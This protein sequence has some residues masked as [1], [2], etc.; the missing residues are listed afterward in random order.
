VFAS[1]SD[2]PEEIRDEI[3]VV[4]LFHVLEHISEPKNFLQ[5][6]LSRLPAVE[7]VVIEVPCSEDPLL[8]VVFSEPFANHTYWSHHCHLHS[9]GSLKLLLSSTCR[10]VS[11]ERIQRYSLAN[12]L[13]WLTNGGPGGDTRFPWASNTEVD[14]RYRQSL[15]DLGCSDTLWATAR[16]LR[17]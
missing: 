4:T 17:N 8:N 11:I 2:V 12:H 10:D 13:G 3:R 6:T 7:Q 9:M 16:P 5:S 14:L 1:L 15:I